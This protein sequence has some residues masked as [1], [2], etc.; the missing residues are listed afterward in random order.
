[1][2]WQ[3]NEGEIIPPIVP[4][5]SRFAPLYDA[6][7]VLLIMIAMVAPWIWLM[8]NVQTTIGGIW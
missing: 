8:W 6:L 2:T 4:V 1:M 7:A 3:L 5:R